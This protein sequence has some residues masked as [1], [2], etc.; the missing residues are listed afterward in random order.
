MSRGL[1]WMGEATCQTL[2]TVNARGL[3]GLRND[4]CLRKGKEPGSECSG[5]SER[6]RKQ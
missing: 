6:D 3:G 1:E 5:G 4:P 2:R